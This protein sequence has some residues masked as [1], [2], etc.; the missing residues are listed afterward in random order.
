MNEI[1][2]DFLAVVKRGLKCRCP[3][4]GQGKLY[5]AYLKQVDECNECGEHLAEYRADDGPAWLTIMI[6]GH[7][8]IPVIMA[9]TRHPE[10]PKWIVLGV[11][12]SM[13]TVFVLALLP[14]TKGFF[15]AMLWRNK[16]VA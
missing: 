2:N 9:Y 14:F 15:I 12:C 7:M 4:C 3:K 13:L 8:T 11:M 1:S 10:W 16:N 5:R 6:A